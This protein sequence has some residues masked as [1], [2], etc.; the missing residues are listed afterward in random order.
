MEDGEVRLQLTVTG[1]EGEIAKSLKLNVAIA[2]WDSVPLMPVTVT[3]NVPAVL[4]LQDSVAVPELVRLVGATEQV[5]PTGALVVSATVPV[6]PL[7]AVTVT[8]EDALVVPSAGAAAG[9]E[10][11]IVKSVTWKVTGPV[12]WFSVPETPVTVT[13]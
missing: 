6:K 4:E 13:V 3:V 2:E 8:V 9:A 11:L 1:V 10:A 12:E 5:G 7:T